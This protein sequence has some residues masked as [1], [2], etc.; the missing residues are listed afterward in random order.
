MTF[1]IKDCRSCTAC[2]G[3]GKIE[4]PKYMERNEWFKAINSL[5]D[6]RPPGVEIEV[7]VLPYSEEESK[8]I[9][10]PECGGKGFFEKEVELQ[11][12]LDFL[13]RKKLEEV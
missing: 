9:P 8:E 7:T 13:V 4:N 6:T 5:M 10:C 2:L 3:T 11:E 1:Y 12:A